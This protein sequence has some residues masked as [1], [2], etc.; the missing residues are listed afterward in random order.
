MKGSSKDGFNDHGEFV[1]ANNP[2][3]MGLFACRVGTVS[4]PAKC[5]HCGVDTMRADHRA[6]LKNLNIPFIGFCRWEKAGMRVK[7]A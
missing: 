1:L 6:R 3:T 2:I 4:D 5:R 7:M